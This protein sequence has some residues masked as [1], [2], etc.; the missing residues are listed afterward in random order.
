[1]RDH[2]AEIK[3]EKMDAAK[4]EAKGYSKFFEEGAYND[5]VVE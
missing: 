4:A 5:K 3:K 2:W 1:V